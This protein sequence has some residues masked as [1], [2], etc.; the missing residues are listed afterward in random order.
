[1]PDTQTHVAY[2]TRSVT[3]D[4]TEDPYTPA[5]M[6]AI[7]RHLEGINQDLS[8]VD[9]VVRES[10]RAHPA[11]T[12]DLLQKAVD[13]WNAVSSDVKARFTPRELRRLQPK[14]KLDD[15]AFRMISLRSMTEPETQ[16]RHGT[17]PVMNLP[18][19]EI[20]L[21]HRLGIQPGQSPTLGEA[22]TISGFSPLTPEAGYWVAPGKE[23][24]ISGDGFSTTEAENRIDFTRLIGGVLQSTG[25]F[26]VIPDMASEKLMSG[27]AP[28]DAEPGDYVVWVSLESESVSNS[29]EVEVMP[30]VNPTATLVDVLPESQLPGGSLLVTGQGFAPPVRAWFIPK[31][32]GAMSFSVDCEQVPGSESTQARLNLPYDMRP[33]QYLLAV[34]GYQQGSSNRLE[35]HVRPFR[36][37]VRFLE[38]RCINE[39]NDPVFGS[40]VG[41]DEVWIRWGIAAD[42]HMA[43]KRSEDDYDLDTGDPPMALCPHDAQ[44]WVPWLETSPAGMPPVGPG[45]IKE[46]LA[47]ATSLTESDSGEIEQANK[48]LDWVADL[49]KDLGQDWVPKVFGCLQ[50]ILPLVFNDVD[51]GTKYLAWTEPELRALTKS[52]DYFEGKLTF[53]GTP[54]DYFLYYL[55]YRVQRALD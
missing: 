34:T 2:F 43:S 25:S 48:W 41:E 50:K 49:A 47:I 11:V 20:I 39:T 32:G 40:H 24:I 42:Q 19:T 7:Q 14:E 6:H 30:S 38:L 51:M 15:D 1:M 52:P 36:Y 17:I 16:L 5:V 33:G 31:Q 9:R 23:F 10:I 13:T 4:P 44:V 21:G 22:P 28:P 35:L 8:T 27:T 26:S 18:W 46:R 54:D 45:E 53:E 37:E 55:T 12:D 3:H 29:V